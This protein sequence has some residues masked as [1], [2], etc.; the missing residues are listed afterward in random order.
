MASNPGVVRVHGMDITPEEAECSGWV[1]AL[2]KKKR[3]SGPGEPK[4]PGPEA[5]HKGEE[6]G[7]R[8]AAPRSALKRIV[9]ASRLPRL[10]REHFKIIVRPRGGLDVKKSNLIHLA[11]ALAMAAALAPEQSRDDTVCPNGIQNILVISTPHEANA[12]AYA[13]IQRIHTKEGPF[14]VAAYVAASDD[15]CK[16]VVR[17]VDP[18]ISDADLKALIVNHRNPKALEVRRIK[19]TPAIVVLF[20][21]HKVPNHVVCGTVML[22]CALYRR[23][24]DICY[25]CGHLGHRADVCPNGEDK[26]KCRGCGL[27]SPP[28]DHQCDPKCAICGGAHQTADRKCSQRFQVP[29]IVRRRRRRRRR[30][31]AAQVA[32]ASRDA[33]VAS[34][35]GR[36]RSRDRSGSRAR[37]RSRG[38]PG[39][40]ARSRSR[41]R[42]R[43]SV[44]IQ[45]G[46][47]W[48]DKVTATPTGKKVTHGTLPEQTEDPRLAALRQ[49]NAQLKEE[50][51]KLR[52]DLELIRQAQNGQGSTSS[53]L[54][55]KP[56]LGQAK[57]KA[58]PP[59]STEAAMELTEETPVSASTPAATLAKGSLAE[60]LDRLAETI[61]AQSGAI[62]QQSEIIR[63]QSE[64]IA[65]LNRRMG[66]MEAKVVDVSRPKV[67]GKV[68]KAQQNSEALAKCTTLKGMLAN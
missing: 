34:G 41:G 59:E 33:S 49:E 27:V 48:V 67:V 60:T 42:S 10:P 46:P 21:G 5:Q 1:T 28:E 7:R 23:Q 8:T 24:V 4:T 62:E 40:R 38:R 66:I 44:R 51:R 9:D 57:R 37:S 65:T 55:P 17:G 22:P 64:A 26:R 50:M 14:D 45:T 2:G 29:Y 3:K 54:A 35:R 43:S 16:G 36:S 20:E 18:E 31:R 11:R 32:A 25:T 53:T 39:S 30:A 47:T 52:A 13:R 63:Q 68:K 61:R 12:R 56:A 19:K 58:P 15:T 6:R